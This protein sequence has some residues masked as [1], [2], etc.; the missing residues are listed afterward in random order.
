VQQT[1]IGRRATRSRLS[2]LASHLGARADDHFRDVVTRC[3]RQAPQTADSIGCALKERIPQPDRTPEPLKR[4]PAEETVPNLRLRR[5][6]TANSAQKEELGNNASVRTAQ[7][8]SPGT[9]LRPGMA[10]KPAETETMI[11][12]EMDSACTQ[13]ERRVGSLGRLNNSRT[14]CEQEHT[15]TREVHT[16]PAWEGLLGL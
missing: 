13:R 15:R 1:A 8:A 12:T 4:S 5:Q 7:Q 3:A 14:R 11:T 6:D 10:G 2:G 9:L 16:S